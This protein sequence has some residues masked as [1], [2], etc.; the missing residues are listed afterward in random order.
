[1]VKD[2]ISLLLRVG[3]CAGYAGAS[4]ALTFVNR[5]LYATYSYKS[6]LSLLLVQCTFNLFI[7]FILMSIKQFINYKSFD[8]LEGYGIKLSS[9]TEVAMKAKAGLVISAMRVIEVLFGL[10]S[11]KAVNIPLFLTIRRCSMI[12]TIVV[13][14]L[15]AGRKP[16]QVL[17]LASFFVVSGALIA[18]YETLDDDMWGYALIMCN[19]FATALVNVV[20]SVYNEKKVVNA[21]D[22][23][24]YFALIGLPL[25]ALITSQTGELSELSGIIFGNTFK[26]EVLP[27]T[28]MI[29]NIMISGSFGILITMT[30]LLCVT[31]NGPISMNITGIFKDVGLTFAGFFFFSDAKVTPSNMFGMSLSLFG[32][33]YF[34]YMKYLDSVKASQEKVKD[35]TT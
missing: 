3:L 32:A 5:L 18:G 30:A 8:F 14:Y 1:M 23:N 34:C 31:I 27:D 10:Y 4:S 29:T 9:L 12:T 11:L 22:L 25:A 2:D 13:D 16:N 17:Q 21:F 33:S 24:F 26:G 6:P 19:N 35:K 7:C 20:A 15:Y 28:T